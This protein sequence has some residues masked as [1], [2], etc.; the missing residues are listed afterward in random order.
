MDFVLFQLQETSSQLEM[1]ICHLD[2]GAG[3]MEGVNFKMEYAVVK[4]ELELDQ[5]ERAAAEKV[6]PRS[7]KL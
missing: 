5:L 2:Y 7:K 1:I 3:Q 4:L 6:C